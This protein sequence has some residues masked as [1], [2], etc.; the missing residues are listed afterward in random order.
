MYSSKSPNNSALK[1]EDALFRI[2][3]CENCFMTK[4]KKMQLKDLFWIK[5]SQLHQIQY[6]TVV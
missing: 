1:E 4:P 2:G 5:A 3:I 6:C